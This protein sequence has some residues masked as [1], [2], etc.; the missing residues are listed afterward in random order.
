MA[1]RTRIGARALGTEKDIVLSASTWRRPNGVGLLVIEALQNED[2]DGFAVIYRRP[3]DNAIVTVYYRLPIKADPFWMISQTVPL[4]NSEPPDFELRQ[5]EGVLYAIRD[6][7]DG[8]GVHLPVGR[9]AVIGFTRGRVIATNVVPID[10]T[11]WLEMEESRVLE[12]PAGGPEN[13]GETPATDG[14]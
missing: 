3:S 8:P 10:W 5:E 11:H 14:E 2:Y 9:K 6:I 12:G 7:A 1:A 4:L 13:R